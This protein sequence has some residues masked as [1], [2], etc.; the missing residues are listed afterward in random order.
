MKLLAL[1]MALGGFTA[2]LAVS[3]HIPLA[4]VESR[5][6]NPYQPMPNAR[7][8]EHWQTAVNV[9]WTQAQLSTLDY[10]MWRESRCKASMLNPDDPNGGSYGLVQVNGFW[11]KWLR[12]R[13]ILKKPS[14]LYRTDINLLSALYIYNYADNRYQNGWGPWN[15]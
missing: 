11:V 7:C 3:G 15:L 14:D 10:L 6:D 2:P 1:V 12:E 8:P 4:Q 13:G 5:G 9:G